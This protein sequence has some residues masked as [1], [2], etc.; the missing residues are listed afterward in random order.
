MDRALADFDQAI[1]LD[2]RNPLPFYNRGLAYRD[3]GD[4]QHA[5]EDYDTALKLDPDDETAK[6]ELRLGHSEQARG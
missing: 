6:R 1:K 3:K 2:P 4:T 5:I